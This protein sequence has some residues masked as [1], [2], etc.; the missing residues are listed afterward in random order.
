[1]PERARPEECSKGHDDK[2]R[3]GEYQTLKP[4]DALLTTKLS[5]RLRRRICVPCRES[6]ASDSWRRI[7]VGARTKKATNNSATNNMA[8]ALDIPR[9]A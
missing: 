6:G 9:D 8:M 4:R 3:C 1:M 5:P 2:Y 7:Q